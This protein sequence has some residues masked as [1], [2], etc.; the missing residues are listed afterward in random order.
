MNV[1]DCETYYSAITSVAAILSVHV[2]ELE[3]FL[4]DVDLDYEFI[5]YPIDCD[6]DTYLFRLF[7]QRFGSQYF[8]ISEVCWFHLSRV[9]PGTDY[10]EGILPLGIVLS[11]IWES[12]EK[13][14]LSPTQKC[15]L[16][17]LKFSGVDDFHYRLKVPNS[18]HYGPY[19]MLVRDV[20]FNNKQVGN[21]DYLGMPEI[22]EDICNG[23]RSKFGEDI[24]ETVANAMERTIVK[25]RSSKY[26]YKKLLAPAL[27]YCW[28]II[29]NEPFS[30][31]ANTCFDGE[32]T[33]VPA[34]AI[35]SVSKL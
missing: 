20:A 32:A 15:N 9:F 34:S 19:A 26:T 4:Q 6:A 24:S 11:R 17:S 33:C 35:V 29:H 27:L 12:L 14:R 5:T 3:I 10:S 21:H 2:Q 22:V 8:S 18:L 7:E 23:Y 1:L 31:Y 13:V 25:F 28:G 16:A 30:P